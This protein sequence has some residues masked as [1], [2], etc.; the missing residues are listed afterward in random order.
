MAGGIVR[1]GFR[2]GTKEYY[3]LYRVD[4]GAGETIVYVD[5]GGDYAGSKC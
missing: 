2:S 1:Q 4:V 3:L 5:V